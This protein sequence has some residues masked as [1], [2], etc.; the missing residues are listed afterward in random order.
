MRRRRRGLLGVAIAGLTVLASFLVAPTPAQAYG[1]LTIKTARIYTNEGCSRAGDGVMLP[2]TR[3]SGGCM[4]YDSAD[5]TFFQ[6]DA[7]GIA[8]KF[9]LHD[10]NGMVGKVEFHPY[11]EKVY[12][13]DTR[14]DG[15]AIYVRT[16]VE[17]GSLRGPYSPTG[18]SNPIDYVVIDHDVAEGA[19][20]Y[21]YIY[22]EADSAPII[23][24][25]GIA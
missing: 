14:N 5:N 19:K 2:V 4:L 11:D 6:Q 13:Y 8:M 1:Y 3:V 12:V 7:G 23:S 25:Y 10:S 20:F 24:M 9:E 18:T 22:D 17:G 15:D 21:V 16:R